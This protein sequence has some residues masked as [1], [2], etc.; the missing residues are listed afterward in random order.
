MSGANG[1]DTL[2]AWFNG[3]ALLKDK[4]PSPV[5]VKEAKSK[6]IAIVGAGM[7]GLMS[8]LVLTQ[9]GM[10]NVKIIEAGQ[11]LGGRVHTEYLTGG[12][13]SYS[14]NEMGPMR[15]P[16]TYTDSSTGETINI[17]DHQLVFQL[18][19]EMNKLNRNDKNL[20]VDFIKW[21][22]SSSN[23]LVY[24]NGFKLPSGLPPTVAQVRADPSLT[25]PVKVQSDSTKALSAEVDKYLPGSDFYTG[26][27][28]NM[29]KAHKQFVGACWNIPRHAPER[30]FADT[31][32]QS[33][34]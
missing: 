6:E 28:K 21:I 13:F 20:S 25:G 1:I 29:F 15:F 9:A 30:S 16:Y 19:G 24:K 2:G 27:A 22:Q 5:D 14:Y 7:S 11:R 23:G 3:V 34:A 12:P 33:R 18:A 31:S 17:T 4:E 8:Y 32:S 26:L 10:K